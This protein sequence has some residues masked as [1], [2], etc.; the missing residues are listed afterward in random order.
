MADHSDSG[1]GGNWIAFLV[2]GLVVVLVIIA[3]VVFKGGG[4]DSARDT[5]VDVNI[6]LPRP[7]LPDTP[8]SHDLPTL[9]LVEPPVLPS[10]D[11]APA[12]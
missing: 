10:P 4:Y 11:P 8:R 7:E 2:G 3:V 6:D 5:R 1:G 12:T 9:P